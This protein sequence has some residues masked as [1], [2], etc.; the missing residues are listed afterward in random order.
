MLSWPS[1]SACCSCHVRASRTT[2]NHAAQPG[3]E[4]CAYLEELSK[5][6]GIN[7]DPPRPFFFFRAFTFFVPRALFIAAFAASSGVSSMPSALA[8]DLAE[9]RPL[10]NRW[11]RLSNAIFTSDPAPY[12]S[13]DIA[14]PNRHCQCQCQCLLWEARHVLDPKPNLARCHFCKRVIA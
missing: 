13:P 10:M 6:P 9:S 7:G 4:S 8:C 3:T 1:S 2:N 14:Q 12:R 11:V 5:L